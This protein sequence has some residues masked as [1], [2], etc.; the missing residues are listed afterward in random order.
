LLFSKVFTKVLNN[1][2]QLDNI[3]GTEYTPIVV[4]ADFWRI[5]HMME[6]SSLAGEGGGCTP[7]SFQPNNI[8]YK[9]AV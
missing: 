2:S 3:T 6:K 4:I 9:V 5:S 7:T 8:T 1:N